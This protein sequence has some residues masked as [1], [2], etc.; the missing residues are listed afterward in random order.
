MCRR[1]LS[2]LE[3]GVPSGER[4]EPLTSWSTVYVLI[5]LAK[6]GLTRDKILAYTP[7]VVGAH[8]D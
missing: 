4:F 6:L 5:G 7:R 2:W 3:G 1:I 8:I